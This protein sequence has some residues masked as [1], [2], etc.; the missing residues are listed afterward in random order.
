MGVGPPERAVPGPPRHGFRGVARPART[1]NRRPRRGVEGVDGEPMTVRAQV[2]EGVLPADR[3]ARFEA[4]VASHRERARRLAWRLVDG[5]D[6]AAEDVAQEA[7][8]RAYRSLG[9]F[10]EESRLSTWFYRILVRQAANH[11]RW[12]AVRERMG[13]WGTPDGPDPRVAPAGDPA[14]RRRIASALASLT[15]R[16]R[17]VFVLMHL[18]GFTVQETA[19]ILG[20]PVGTVKSHLHR[21]LVH[22]RRELADLREPAE[23]T[24]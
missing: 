12:R 21:A 3:E 7:F 24:A 16:Q 10:R 17:E 18:E 13:G 23:E 14:L 5:D 9:R 11:R 4:F 15:R 2:L 6:G 8:L 20:K 19:G 22:L 1:V